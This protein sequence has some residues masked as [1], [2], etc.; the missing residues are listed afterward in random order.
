MESK[1]EYKFGERLVKGISTAVSLYCSIIIIKDMIILQICP[2]IKYAIK[3]SAIAFALFSILT[4]V[5][6]FIK[7]KLFEDVCALVAG[8]FLFI[9]LILLLILSI[10]VM[11]YDIKYMIV[12]I[13]CLAML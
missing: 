8:I 6:I 9:L 7:Q 11:F 5:S 3:I 2:N 12:I 13:I 1:N 10:N 4:I